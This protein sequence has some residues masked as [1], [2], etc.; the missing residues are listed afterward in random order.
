M[1]APKKPR[2]APYRPLRPAHSPLGSG[3]IASDEGQVLS[4][5]PCSRIAPPYPT[6]TANTKCAKFVAQAERADLALLAKLPLRASRAVEGELRRLVIGEVRLPPILVSGRARWVPVP[7]ELFVP[8]RA[9]WHAKNR[10]PERRVFLG[11]GGD[12]FRTATT[13]ACLAAAVPRFSPHDLR[14]RRV[15]LL[16]LGRDAVGPDR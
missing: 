7:P 15:S 14:H 5:G 13:R 10:T 2:T 12:R 1:S 3:E 8:S 16:H 6:S 4:I 9:L 11:F